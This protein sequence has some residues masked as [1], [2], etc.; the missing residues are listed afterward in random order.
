[1][2]L[3]AANEQA[4]PIPLQPFSRRNRNPQENPVMV[5]IEPKPKPK[6]KEVVIVIDDPRTGR[7]HLEF[8]DSEAVVPEG[9]VSAVPEPEV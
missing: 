8:P 7:A 9:A 6:H 3:P 2:K 4:S 1:M 5:E